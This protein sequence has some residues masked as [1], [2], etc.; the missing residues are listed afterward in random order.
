MI[1]RG[2]FINGYS[3]LFVVIILMDICD[4]SWLFV[5]ILLIAIGCYSIN[6]YWWLL[7]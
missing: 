6:D 3:C 1:I 5:T 7:Y 2:Y 4:Y